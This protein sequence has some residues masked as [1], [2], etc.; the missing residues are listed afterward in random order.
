MVREVIVRQM[1]LMNWP[2]RLWRGASEWNG[3]N[4]Y[5]WIRMLMRKQMQWL[6]N[7]NWLLS[8]VAMV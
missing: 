3:E 1:G 2:L 6:P 4:E 7:R 8:V 5:D